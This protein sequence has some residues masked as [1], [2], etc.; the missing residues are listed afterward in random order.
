MKTITI[1]PLEKD[2]VNIILYELRSEPSNYSK[3][4]TPYN[5]KDESFINAFLNKRKDQ[6]CGIFIND[7]PVGFYMLRGMDAGYDI[8]SFSNWISEKHHG[9]GLASLAMRHAY[10]ICKLN[11]IK[12]MMT[13]LHPNNTKGR[14]FFEKFGFRFNRNDVN[15]GELI[16]HIR[17]Q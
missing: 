10:T 8:P 7:L 5:W 3:N 14:E 9:L 11:L 1:K 15:S 4:F 2:H 6:F 17:I 13:K 12:T 16:Y